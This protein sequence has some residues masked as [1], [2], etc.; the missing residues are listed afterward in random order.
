[1]RYILGFISIVIFTAGCATTSYSYKNFELSKK[2]LA[3]SKEKAEY[4]GYVS[5]FIVSQNQQRLDDDSGCY[6]IDKGTKVELILTV[7]KAGMISS[8]DTS[9][10]SRKAKCFR[11]AYIGAKM[12]A[13][14]FA[15]IAIN[16]NMN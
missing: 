14:P 9:T 8:S 1:M 2:L 5:E 15:P 6:K 13:P 12:P 11:K 16:L 3:S 7:N 10:D 4:R